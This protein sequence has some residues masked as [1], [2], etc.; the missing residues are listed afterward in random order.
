MKELVACYKAQ[1]ELVQELELQVEQSKAQ[2]EK[3]KQEILERME[4]EGIDRTATFEGIGFVTRM[5][6]RL[7][8]S[9]SEENKP[10]VFEAVRSMG[11]EDLIKEVIN[12]QTLSAF[13]SECLENG[14]A[15][16]EGVSYILKPNIRLY[17]K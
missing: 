17:S 5:K 1:F 12:P 15:I 3:L 7:Y 8:A 10:F 13:V 4:A 16:P 2:L 11:R 14:Q 9:I 6:P